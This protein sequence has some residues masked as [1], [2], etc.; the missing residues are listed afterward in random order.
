MNQLRNY[1]LV[2]SAYWAFTIT[3]GALRMLVL[4]YFHTE[5]AFTPIQI[6]LLFL[7]YEIFGVITNLVGGWIGARF[8][9]K[10]T[11]FAGLATQ[12]F[13]LSAL[14]LKD[15][16]WPVALLVGYVMALQALSG[17]AKD[18]TKMSSK[19]AVKLLVPENQQG[20]L[21]KW[22][23]L[24]TGS[25]N[26]LKGVGFFVGAL[27]LQLVGFNNSLYGMAGMLVLFFV[28]SLIWI[29]GDLGR[30]KNKPKFSAMFS[31]SKEINWLSGARLFLFGARDIWFVVAVPVF[32]HETL[33]WSFYQVGGFMALW[34]IG[35]GF[36]QAS[37]PGLIRKAG[38]PTGRTA[39]VLA[40][41]LG[42]TMGGL[43]LVMQQ[44][45]GVPPQIAIMVGLALFG[46]IFALNSSVHSYLIVA[47][48]DRDQVAMNVG[49]YYM[50]N[51]GGRLVG[52]VL[53]GI[54]FQYY[55]LTGC[56]WASLGF[57]IVSTLV[58]S[59][60]PARPFEGGAHGAGPVPVVTA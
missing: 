2:T 5:L 6:A 3:D 9:L 41:L 39:M 52:T 22:V 58:S 18:L 57:A 24:L 19:S 43:A 60:L 25:K 12:I 54:M 31:K 32:L 50:A 26:A 34:V 56:L 8:G 49:F 30:S 23:A 13:A 20:Q 37:T 55:G 59:K 21:F 10:V 40:L 15:A 27:L 4:L 45:W 7:F 29:R 28:I 17:I 14:T 1:M 38:I 11:L 42:I 33:Q 47:Y 48:S 16:G 44:G 53:S 51:A 46:L 35:Y 36:V